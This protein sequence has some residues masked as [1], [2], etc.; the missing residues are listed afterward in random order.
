MFGNAAV[1]NDN[2][3]DE[4][5]TSSMLQLQEFDLNSKA[6]RDA[7]LGK[8]TS[9]LNLHDSIDSCLPVPEQLFLRGGGERE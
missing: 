6:N 9:G 3:F 1:R 8:A 4:T 2:L 5:N 7:L